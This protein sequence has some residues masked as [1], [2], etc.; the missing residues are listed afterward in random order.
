MIK[1]GIIG[2]TGYAGEELVRL[3][4]AHPQVEIAHVVSKSFAGKKL[5]EI[6]GSYLSVDLTL[7]DMDMD[8]KAYGYYVHEHRY[9]PD[10]CFRVTDGVWKPAG[11]RDYFRHEQYYICLL[12]TS[13]CV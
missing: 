13:R 3:L 7:E 5:S 1:A 11:Q 9:V 6:Y 12:Y 2:A 4:T 8:G 10:S